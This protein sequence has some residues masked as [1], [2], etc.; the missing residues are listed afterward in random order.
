MTWP[1]AVPFAERRGPDTAA[2]EFVGR[3]S[4]RDLATIGIWET[5]GKMMGKWWNFMK[6]HGKMMFSFQ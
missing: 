2:I 1:R 4:G 3:C 5:Y 6:S